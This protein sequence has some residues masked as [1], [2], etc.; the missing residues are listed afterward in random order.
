MTDSKTNKFL[1]IAEE[2]KKGN[3]KEK[4]HG[5]FSEFLELFEAKPGI[6]VLAHR[7]LY[8]TIVDHGITRMSVVIISSTEI[9][10]G[11]MIISRA[12]SLEWKGR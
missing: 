11:P 8:D 10:L 5:S 2:H 1:K 4:F 3:K 12:N 6:E 7:R 9:R